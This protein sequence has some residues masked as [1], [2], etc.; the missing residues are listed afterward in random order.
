MLRLE[1][2]DKNIHDRQSFDCGNEELNKYIKE[3]ARQDI[4]NGITQVYVFVEQ[5]DHAP[6]KIYGYFTLNAF[7]I[8]T[9]DIISVEKKVTSKYPTIPAI[10]IGRLAKERDQNLIKGSEILFTALYKAKA[11][12]KEIGAA[13]VIVHAIDD[14]A[15][16]FYQKYGFDKVPSKESTLIFSL[17]SLE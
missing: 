13:Y 10:L 9:E 2:M 7:L 1:V 3:I 15:I 17:K 5:H 4:I 14:K 11:I 12:S 16:D 8:L 6:K